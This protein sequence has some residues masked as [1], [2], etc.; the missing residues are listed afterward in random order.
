MQPVCRIGDII[1]GT[2]WDGHPPR[3]YVGVWISG[4]PTCSAENLDIVRIGDIGVTDCGHTIVAIAGAP[5]TSADNIPVHR[6]GDAV[7]VVGGG[8]GVS[9]TG[10]PTYSAE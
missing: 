2:C 1:V 7:M 5:T 9:I 3:P 4:S 8:D 6:I 10:S